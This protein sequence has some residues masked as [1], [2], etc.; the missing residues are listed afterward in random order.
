MSLALTPGDCATTKIR[1]AFDLTGPAAIDLKHYCAIFE[2]QYGSKIDVP[3]VVREMLIRGFAT[4]KGFQTLK[5]N[6]Q[7][8][9]EAEKTQAAKQAPRK[10][11]SKAPAADG[12][13]AFAQTVEE[14]G[15][16]ENDNGAAREP[17]S[18]L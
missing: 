17:E 2:Q 1:L 13:V 14:A 9:K 12:T 18:T 15:G 8:T 3:T 11:A 6:F 16:T 10:K 7:P 4:D 5:R